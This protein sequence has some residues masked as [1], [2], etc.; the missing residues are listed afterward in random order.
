MLKI[1]IKKE[2]EMKHNKMFLFIME[3][4]R[5]LIRVILFKKYQ[6]L[7]KLYLKRGDRAKN[8]GRKQKWDCN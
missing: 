8:R 5:K 7:T 3:I 4:F 2:K 6:K 1:K